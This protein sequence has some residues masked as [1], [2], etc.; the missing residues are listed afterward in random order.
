MSF[1]MPWGNFSDGRNWEVKGDPAW[2]TTQGASTAEQ[3]AIDAVNTHF[4]TNGQSID[5]TA[6]LVD[7]NN[8]D[9]EAA[10]KGA[11]EEWTVHGQDRYDYERFSVRDGEY[12]GNA[13]IYHWDGQEGDIGP[14]FPELELEIFGAP[15]QRGEIYGPEIAK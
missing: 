6:P 11:N 14:E 15:D 8:K 1:N 10:P 3:P 2:S 7:H 4:E 9:S 12:D 5:N 13:R